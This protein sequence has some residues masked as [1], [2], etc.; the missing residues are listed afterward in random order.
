[1]INKELIL[2]TLQ[3]NG[4]GLILDTMLEFVMQRKS[5]KTA[6]IPGLTVSIWALYIVHE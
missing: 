6:R 2:K 5:M 3:G 4:R 1:M